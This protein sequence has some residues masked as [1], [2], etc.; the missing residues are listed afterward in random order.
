MPQP[1]SALNPSPLQAE[2][3]TLIQPLMA[4]TTGGAQAPTLPA[5]PCRAV[6]PAML[7]V[8]SW[9]RLAT[10]GTRASRLKGLIFNP[11][12]FRGK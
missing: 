9:T 2:L 12:R 10:C 11:V 8:L 3:V 1:A 4:S 5:R 6:Q 7:R